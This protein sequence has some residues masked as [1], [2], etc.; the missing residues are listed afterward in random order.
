MSVPGTAPEVV[1]DGTSMT[2]SLAVRNTLT[3]REML[4]KVDLSSA[5]PDPR[6]TAERFMRVSMTTLQ[7]TPKIAECDPR[8][9]VACV[10]ESAQLGLMP[11]GLTGEAYLVPFGKKCTMIIGYRGLL[12][13][14]R[15]SG[16]IKSLSVEPVYEGDDFKFWLGIKPNIHHVPNPDTDDREDPSKLTHVYAV[17]HLRDGGVQFKIMSRGEVDRIRKRSRSGSNGPWVTDYVAM[18][19]KTVLRQLCKMLPVSTQVMRAVT[20]DEA[21]E[22]GV[23]PTLLERQEDGSFAPQKSETDKMDELARK[24]QADPT[25]EEPDESVATTPEVDGTTTEEYEEQPP[26]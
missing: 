10:V 17:A 5:L 11:D 12:K 18:A 8:S 26:V 2:Q 23:D 4:S 22:R 19:C 14:A 1:W 20:T 21:S 24:L 25:D 7:R 6:V 3:V 9:I 13:L 15:N 16:E